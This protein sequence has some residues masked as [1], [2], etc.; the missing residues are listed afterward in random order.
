MRVFSGKGLYVD[1]NDLEFV[2]V[3]VRMI[4]LE[5][6]SVFSWSEKLCD[7]CCVVEGLLLPVDFEVSP[8]VKFKDIFFPKL[9]YIHGGH[10]L[11]TK[12]N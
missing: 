1:P 12:W 11:S 8:S 6:L 5:D 7:W 10:R 4:L 2:R 9:F 3:R